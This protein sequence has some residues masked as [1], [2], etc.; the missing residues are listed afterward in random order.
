MR[1][2]DN[3]DGDRD[4]RVDFGDKDSTNLIKRL[5]DNQP[6]SDTHKIRDEQL[7]EHRQYRMHGVDPGADEAD[8]PDQRGSD[9]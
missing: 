3:P 6:L 2:E 7:G 5:T 9:G 8:Q 4:E 1:P